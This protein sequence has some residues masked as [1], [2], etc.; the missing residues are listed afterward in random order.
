MTSR[1]RLCPRRH[2]LA[3]GF[4]GVT[5]T[6]VIPPKTAQPPI[7]G[8]AEHNSCSFPHRP[9]LQYSIDCDS[10]RLR[11]R[12]KSCHNHCCCERQPRSR[13]S[14]L[15][16][17][18]PSLRQR[19]EV[20]SQTKLPAVM[21]RTQARAEPRHIEEGQLYQKTANTLR[22]PEERK[23]AVIPPQ[24]AYAP[25]SSAWLYKGRFTDHTTGFGH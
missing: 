21:H 18:A 20:A 17:N 23:V 3:R 2:S 22:S 15:G 7:T 9:T 8:R 19:D 10:F 16:I 24:Q 11:M 12:L 1:V 25:S 14:H 6:L 5:D 13:Q 4:V